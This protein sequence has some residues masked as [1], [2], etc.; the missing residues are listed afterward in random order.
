MEHLFTEA[1]KIINPL[2]LVLIGLMFFY[3]YNRLDSKIEKIDNKVD[4]FYDGL[5]TKI[6]KNQD[7]LKG[8]I[9]SINGRVDKLYDLILDLYKTLSDRKA[10]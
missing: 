3:F 10:A 7:E 9:K 6:D 2:Q 4:K 1:V 8:E 5:N